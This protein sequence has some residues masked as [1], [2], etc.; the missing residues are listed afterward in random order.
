[1]ITTQP[2]LTNSGPRRPRNPSILTK[3]DSELTKLDRKVIN[4]LKKFNVKPL[5]EPGEPNSD[6]FQLGKVLFHER[7][8]TG[9][10][11]QAC[12]SCHSQG[13]A[14][15]SQKSLAIG[16]GSSGFMHIQRKGLDRKFF[17][18]SS[19]PLFNRASSDFNSMFR[20][21]RIQETNH[22]IRSPVGDSLPE[23]V[24]DIL[25]AQAMMPPLRRIEMRGEKGDKD[26]FGLQNELA[27]I[28]DSKPKKVWN[29]IMGRLLS[30]DGYQELFRKAF[31]NIN[32]QENL[33]FYHAARSIAHYIKHAFHVSDTPFDQYL[34]GH[35][36]A[37]T[38]RQKQGAL[39]FFGK[40]RCASCHNGPLLTDHEFHNIGVP[41]LGP[42]KE[43]YKPLDLGR[44]LVTGDTGDRF[45][46]RTPP[47]R[48]VSLTAP[49][50]HNG[51][52]MS[53]EGAVRHHLDPKQS[54]K[55]YNEFQLARDIALY[56][57]SPNWAQQL[58]Q[59]VP[60]GAGWPLIHA[61]HNSQST[62]KKVLTTLDPMV[63]KT[64]N[65]N[66][67]EF[68]DLMYFLFSLTSPSWVESRYWNRWGPLEILT[69][70]ERRRHAR[71]TQ[72]V[73]GITPQAKEMPG[74]VPQQRWIY[75]FYPKFAIHGTKTM[76]RE[77]MEPKE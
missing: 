64:I 30:Y 26:A 38:K 24:N 50:M 23:E 40:A 35:P 45:A 53:L 33:E 73:Q 34:K 16:T 72:H 59:F 75:R 14:T 54:L 17:P 60:N 4:R 22:G 74:I 6:L 31:P 21:G 77:Y 19:Q 32:N 44:H 29:A 20:D 68:N 28:S 27:L 15:V 55:S 9:N 13:R 52:F 70:E 5:D 51:A 1:M 41:Q 66:E 61:V 11:D 67:S 25:V 62:Q 69:Q 47:L 10:R 7:D 46:F 48:N 57:R 76:T 65:L 36:N 2:A 63:K 58:N 39:L 56:H 49:Y 37:L 18:R 8:L 12:F 3:N 42:G 43:P 71:V